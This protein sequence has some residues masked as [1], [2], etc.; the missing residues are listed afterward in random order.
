[1]QRSR[2][3]I[4][5]P[6]NWPASLFVMVLG[7]I[8]TLMRS[9]PRQQ[10]AAWISAHIHAFE[11]FSGVPRLLVPIT[12]GRSKPCV[13]LRSG[14]QPTTSVAMHYD[15]ES[16][17]RAPRHPKDKA[18]VEVGVK[19]S[20]AGSFR[21]TPAEVFRL[22]D[23]NNAIRR[24]A[25]ALNQRPFRKREG[26]RAVCSLAVERNALRPCPPTVRH[27]PVVLRP[28]QHRLPHRFD[29]NLLQR[30]VRAGARP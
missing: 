19:L 20:N 5:L 2:Y 23:L 30:A 7:T 28:S 17:R 4:R 27:E 13:P 10:L 22:A 8:P 21:P 12:Y 14:S 24:T 16:C 29:A 3:T 11:Y 15:V 26:S 18:K 9:H 1:V 25:R 6:R